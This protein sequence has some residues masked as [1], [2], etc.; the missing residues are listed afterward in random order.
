MVNVEKET[1]SSTNRERFELPHWL[2]INYRA[3]RNIQMTFCLIQL[4]NALPLVVAAVDNFFVFLS[5]TKSI[6]C[7]YDWNIFHINCEFL[8]TKSQVGIE[9]GL[10]NQ[11]LPLSIKRRN[12]LHPN[13]E[14][15]KTIAN[16]K[17]AKYSWQS[18]RGRGRAC[19]RIGKIRQME[20]NCYQGN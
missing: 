19:T 15:K 20:N 18:V 4:A 11:L 9:L 16:K 8:Q 14:Q 7:L 3:G 2:I 6:F 5:A 10:L 17:Q 13:E 1:F 12:S